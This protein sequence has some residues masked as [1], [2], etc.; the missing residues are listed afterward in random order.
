MGKQLRA[1]LDLLLDINELP[2]NWESILQEYLKVIIDGT[3]IYLE[4]DC[5]GY[6]H[7]QEAVLQEL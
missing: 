1:K 6:I 4:P 2:D 7:F 3:P 5:Q